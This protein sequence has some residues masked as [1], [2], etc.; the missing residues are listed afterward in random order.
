M[1]QF[2]DEQIDYLWNRLAGELEDLE[3]ALDQTSPVDPSDIDRRIE[4]LRKIANVKR[5]LADIEECDATAI[6][7]AY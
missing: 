4:L 5:G 2:S 3:A 7:E 6:R 1:G